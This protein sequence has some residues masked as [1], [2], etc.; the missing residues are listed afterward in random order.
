MDDGKFCGAP[1][2]WKEAENCCLDCESGRWRIVCGESVD[3][4]LLFKSDDADNFSNFM[5][6][7]NVDVY[8]S[9]EN[10]YFCGSKL[11]FGRWFD[12]SG[13]DEYYGDCNAE[14]WVVFPY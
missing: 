14:V 13:N 10:C 3:N 8:V 11:S 7:I 12:R 5:Y 1:V 4:S 2:P 9:L 6:C